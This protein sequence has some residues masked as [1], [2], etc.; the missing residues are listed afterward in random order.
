MESHDSLFGCNTECA[1]SWTHGQPAATNTYLLRTQLSPPLAI[2]LLDV[3]HGG[4]RGG[5]EGSREDAGRGDNKRCSCGNWTTGGVA[6]DCRCATGG[7][8]AGEMGNTGEVGCEGWAHEEVEWKAR[9]KRWGN[10]MGNGVSN[11]RN[12]LRSAG[13]RWRWAVAMAM[14]TFAV[15]RGG[16]CWT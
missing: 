5:E 15:L 7:D 11:P 6:E 16:H 12:L 2:S 1:S 9:K 14:T 8:G 13:G 3:G 4:G 10:W